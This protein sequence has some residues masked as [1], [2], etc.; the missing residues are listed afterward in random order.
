MNSNNPSWN[1][2]SQVKDVKETSIWITEDICGSIKWGSI[3]LLQ[4]NHFLHATI[5]TSLI[6]IPMH[7]FPLLLSFLFQHCATFLPSSLI[8]ISCNR[9]SLIYPNV[10]C[11]LKSVWVSSNS[12]G[13]LQC[14]PL[15]CVINKQHYKPRQQVPSGPSC[16]WSGIVTSCKVSSV[17]WWWAS[18]RL[19]T[20]HMTVEHSTQQKTLGMCGPWSNDWR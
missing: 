18:V 10:L 8:G 9:S 5:L 12:F 1:S 13:T 6:F 16:G 4:V 17:I 2:N 19:P 14:P 15:T 7:E 11:A 20:K 3:N